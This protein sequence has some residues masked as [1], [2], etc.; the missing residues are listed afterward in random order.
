MNDYQYQYYG[1]RLTSEVALPVL[2]AGGGCGDPEIRLRLGPVAD[3]LE[4]AA[5]SS[6][7]LE[8]GKD[9]EAIARIGDRL[10]FRIAGGSEIVLD[11]DKSQDPAEVET[12]FTSLVAGVVLHQRHALPLHASAVSIDGSAVAFSGPSGAGKSTF[13]SAFAL[14]GYP[15]IADDVCRIQFNSGGCPTVSPGPLRLRLWPDMAMAL[16]RAPETLQAARSHHP[17]RLLTDVDT[18]TN[19]LPLRVLIRLSLDV[20]ASE[21][22]LE[23]MRGPQSVMPIDELVYRARLGRTLGRQVEIFKQLTELGAAIRVYRLTRPDGP[24]DLSR[25]VDLVRQALSEG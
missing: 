5:W 15:L 17:K 20:Q 8:I 10:R 3:H 1:Y 22:R 11:T 4:S 18:E 12:H 25:L 7:F 19:S 9:G 16:G 14:Q 23:R 2:P 6:P 13:A 24:P 21:P